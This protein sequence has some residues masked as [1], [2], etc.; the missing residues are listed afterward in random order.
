M[1]FISTCPLQVI[2]LEHEHDLSVMHD[3]L[4]LVHI[5]NIRGISIVHT[6]NIRG[7]IRG[8]S[9]VHTENIRGNIRGIS[10]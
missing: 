4:V 8:I 5:E 1:A 3:V 9:K 10:I 2:V 6:E 7:N